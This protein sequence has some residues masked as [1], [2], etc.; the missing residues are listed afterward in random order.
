MDRQRIRS[1]DQGDPHA[2]SHLAPLPCILGYGRSGRAHHGVDRV[3]AL[4]SCNALGAHLPG[5]DQGAHKADRAV[6]DEGAK[7]GPEELAKDLESMGTLQ[8]YVHNN[9]IGKEGVEALEEVQARRRASG[10][11]NFKVQ[12]L[13]VQQLEEEKFEE[14]P[15]KHRKKRRIL[16]VGKKKCGQTSAEIE[17]GEREVA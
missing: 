16:F 10:Q 15:R 4:S 17:S 1:V 7:G 5:F 12:E 2:A 3:R 8:L 6:L 11:T 13:G 14:K 9:E